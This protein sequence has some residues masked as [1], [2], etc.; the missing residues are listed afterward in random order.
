MEVNYSL[1]VYAR[2]FSLTRETNY[3]VLL[4]Y[5]INDKEVNK[6]LIG[7]ESLSA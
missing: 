3:I 4:R 7:K 2:L 1:A 5:N 6:N